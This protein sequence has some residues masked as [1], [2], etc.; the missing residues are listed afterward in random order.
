MV[1]LL[2]L[3]LFILNKYRKQG[4]LGLFLVF[5]ASLAAQGSADL[6][7]KKLSTDLQDTTRARLLNEL[8]WE[9]RFSETRNAEAYA[10]EALQIAKK[11]KVYATVSKAYRTLALVHTIT[12]REITA[13]LYYD[14]AI[15]NARKAHDLILEALCVNNKAGMFGDFGDFDQAIAIYSHGLDI[16]LTTNN[17]KLIA[18]FYNNLADAYQNIGGKTDMVQKYYN[19]ALTYNLDNQNWSAACLNSANLASE[20]AAIGNHSE[21]LKELQR[22]I[23]LLKKTEQGT[24]LYG[25]A[26]NEISTVYLKLGNS[27]LSLKYALISYKVLDSL[28]MP[29]NVLHPLLNITNAEIN[30]RNLKSAWEHAH[31]LLKLATE[32]KAKIY[33]KEAYHSLSDAAKIEGKYEKALEYFE[34]YK[35]WNDSVFQIEREKNIAGVQFKAAMASKGMEMKYRVELK[36]KENRELARDNRN[37]KRG[38]ILGSIILLVFVGLVYMLFNAAKRQRKLNVELQDKNYLVEKQTEEKDLLIHEIH[39]RVKNNLT[40]LQ[41][42]F[43]LQSKSRVNPEIKQVLAESQTRLLSMALVHQH[44]YENDNEGGLD[45][46]AFI[47]NLLHDISETFTSSEVQNVNYQIN[48]ADIEIGIKLA[49]PVGLI[50]N[51]LITNSLKYAFTPQ[52]QGKIEV[53]VSSHNNLLKIEYTDNGPGLQQDF[54]LNSTGFGFKILKLLTRQIKAEISYQ[55]GEGESTFY[56]S[57]PLANA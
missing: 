16:A 17:K 24:Y 11:K 29:N 47:D 36:D 53:N 22:S 45:V 57:I 49:I 44:L 9:L 40:M 20:Y 56:L 23:G 5:T 39:H 34:Q 7:R 6:L 14:S 3:L 18:T 10:N 41:S 50:L 52:N 54:D 21:A 12:D 4:F 43:Y 38:I 13:V 48:G 30:L 42:L 19:L 27:E 26:N 33:I 15:A 25:A 31:L 8:G 37:L 28:K 1:F 2:N 51:E 46:K 35:R 55:K 32:K